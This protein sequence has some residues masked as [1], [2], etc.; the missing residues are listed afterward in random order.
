MSVSKIKVSLDFGTSVMEVGTLVEQNQVVFFRFHPSFLDKNLNISLFKLKQTNDIIPC[1]KEPFDGL[2]G[3]FN[4]SVPD[5]WGRLLLDRKLIEK[6][7][8]P[9]EISALDRL[10]LVGKKAQGALIYEPEDN[11]NIAY[12][13]TFDLDEIANE[14]T[15]LLKN[16][17]SAFLDDL[18]HL[19]GNSV[20]ARPKVLVN[21]SEKDDLF[22]PH[23]TGDFEPWIIKFSSLNDLKDSA[24]IEYALYLLSKKCGIEMH[25]SKLFTSEKGHSFFATKRF[26]REKNKRLH[27]HSACGLLHDNFR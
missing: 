1:P 10:S 15:E 3:V 21:Y 4:D 20:G 8:N 14:S 12:P 6:G 5:G 24:N 19:G 13:T 22:S 25:A 23:P 11:E 17:N 16:G 9:R 7:I 18:Y 26:D 2:P 27:F